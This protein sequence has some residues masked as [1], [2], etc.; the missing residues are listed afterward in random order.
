MTRRKCSSKLRRRYGCFKVPRVP[1]ATTKEVHRKGATWLARTDPKEK[2]IE[3][4]E[5]FDDLKPLEKK[6]I[7][8]HER[9]H[10]ETGTDHNE[11]FLAALKRLIIANKMS[12][13][14]AFELENANCHK[15]H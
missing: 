6:Y 7:T 4:S 13:R 1:G 14:I 3:F 5:Y 9:A 11:A 12:W 8:L 10:L 2:T 15:D